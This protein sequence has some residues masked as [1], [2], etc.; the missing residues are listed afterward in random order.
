M[1]LLAGDGKVDELVDVL[2]QIEVCVVARNDDQLVRHFL[3]L[4]AKLEAD[5][6]IVL[7]RHLELVEAAVARYGGLA[8]QT[9]V[10]VNACAALCQIDNNVYRAL[11]HLRFRIRFKE[12]VGNIE[13]ISVLAFFQIVDWNYIVHIKPKKFVQK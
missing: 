12:L 5:V 11:F 10:G 1:V 3:R 2:P 9:E 8:R 6:R 4:V 13:L 7:K